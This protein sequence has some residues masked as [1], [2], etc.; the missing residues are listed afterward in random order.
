MGLTH[1]VR[2]CVYGV[3]LLVRMSHRLATPQIVASAFCCVLTTMGAAE[4]TAEG[5]RSYNLPRG[6]AATTLGQ[7]AGVSGRQIVFMMDKVR[8][9]QTQAIAGDYL[10]HE[11]LERMLAGTAL[12]AR[13]DAATGAFVISRV[14]PREAHQPPAAG[15][16]APQTAPPAQTLMKRKSPFSLLAGWLALAFVPTAGI[17]AAESRTP[18]AATGTVSGFVRNEAT[19]TYLEGAQVSV[20]PGGG[21][22]LSSR[23]GRF[24]LP[25]V[26]AGRQTLVVAYSGLETKS[27][28]VHVEAGRTSEYEVGLTSPVYQLSKFI[29]EGEREG[30]SLAI[31]QQRNA[32]NVKNV[33]SADAFGSVADLNIGNFLLRLPGISKEESEGEVYKIQVR[34]MNANLNAVSVDGTR[35]A[36]G[37]TR[38]F[39][40]GF[41][42]DKVPADFIETIEVTKAMTPD[43]DADSIGGSVNLKTK[44]ALDRKG[45]RITYQ[46]GNTYNVA[47][48]TFRPM[49]NVGYSDL[50]AAGKL[51]ILVT[52]SYNE[53]NK[54]RDSNN[55]LFEATTATDRPVWFNAS[56]FGQDQLKHTRAG[57]G[58]RLDYKL[59]AVTR[60]Y[61]N[62]M[63]SLYE[64]QLR[65]RWGVMSVPAAANIVS[66]TTKVTETRN[67][68]FTFTENYRERDVRTL[69]LQA[70]GET[71]WRGAKVDF[72][73]NYSPSK[74]TEYRFI[75][76][77]TVA[78]VGFR[79]DRSVTHDWL[80]LSQISG[81]DVNDPRNSL[82]STV[83]IPEIDSRDTII[84]AQLNARKPLETRIPIAIKSGLR[85]RDQTR[86]KDQTRRLFS[87]VGPNGVA[88]PVGATNDDDLGR[89]FD[90][91][92]DYTPAGALP[93]LQWF[94][95]PLV[96]DAVRTSPNLFREDLVGGARD[97]ARFD[98]KVSE[99]VIAG[100]VMAEVR[101]GRLGV[102]A[103]VRT[104]ETEVK[105]EGHKQ[106]VTPAERAR[107]AAWVGTVTNEEN[108]RRT[109]AE[110]A[111]EAR[112]SG[113]YRDYFPSIH[114]KYSLT[115]NLLARASYSTGIGRP[116]FGQILFDSTINNDAQA[117]V[118]TNPGL[119]PQYSDNIDLTLEY[120]YEPAGLV[121]V[122]AF[123][124]KISDFIFRSRAGLVESGNPFGE[125][126]NGYSLTTDL[127]G[128]SAQVRGL[129]ASF[130]Q[131]FSNLPGFWRGFGAFAN[132]TW[133]QTEGDYG[134][135]GANITKSELPNFTPRSGN[136]GLSYIGYDWTV[137][138]KAN[139]TGAR[140][141]VYQADASRRQ[142]GVAHTPVDLNLA[143]A[144]SP[145]IRLFVDVINVFNVGI[146]HQ[147]MFVSDR[148]TSSD[149][150]STVI[151]F[152]V[153]GN[154]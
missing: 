91:G 46:F 143:Y 149:R 14:P 116:N 151:K 69:N 87:Y 8:G 146:G 79:Q 41:E 47:K 106:E 60:V 115:R 145:K 9:E 105:G 136:I 62:T 7:F 35:A 93:G 99:T 134:T 19:G 74:G 23:D 40:R 104:E 97:S 20:E 109:L 43:Q 111:G 129:E 117:I 36:N 90:K 144:V 78:G 13:Q 150:S 58:L 18:S 153:G 107:R 84:G 71:V 86:R 133:L 67:Q 112:A 34:G 16:P 75:P 122:A 39:D 25:A 61:L 121:S 53:T 50:V 76:T 4:Q 126:Y 32:G 92:Y 11:A 37:S 54:P 64:D 118:A 51:G 42:I 59:G 95:L 28:P 139:Y 96:Q 125:A 30:N 45:R 88:G 123:Q 110:F 12:V 63:T 15:T 98:N 141:L 31:T 5:K 3:L 100:Y 6:D 101:L 137:R 72:N 89:F 65:R 113:R 114:F 56:A 154:F 33:I 55:I 103:G 10:P 124:K 83:D 73:A 127:N 80:A 29:V 119:K 49:G 27:L 148:K 17:D 147:Y 70:G 68:N 152:G 1:Y 38:S 52:A 140:L 128:G 102:V 81:P 77:R 24:T 94:N 44:S 130:Q 66:V 48:Q 108:V 26:P 85:F 57:F 142:Y 22:T 132:F 135:A 131:Q 2:G 21:A 82:L 120:Y 138:V